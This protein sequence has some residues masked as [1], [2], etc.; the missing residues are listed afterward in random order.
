M[1]WV[2]LLSFLR[3]ISGPFH[4]WKNCFTLV[5]YEPFSFLVYET[6]CLPFRTLVLYESFSFLVYESFCP[7]L[8]DLTVQLQLSRL[9][10]YPVPCPPPLF[11]FPFTPPFISKL[12]QPK[13]CKFWKKT[14]FFA[15]LNVSQ[16]TQLQFIG[17]KCKYQYYICI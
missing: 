14:A 16:S 12:P 4:W 13:L 3:P 9:L 10:I 11:L 8:R 6:F 1:L 7:P 2:T 17:I 5:L 15:K